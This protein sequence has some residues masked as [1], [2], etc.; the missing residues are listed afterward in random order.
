LEDL[1][2]EKFGCKVGKFE[3][4]KVGKPLKGREARDE[5]R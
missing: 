1:K 5:K 4:F 2:I 3:N